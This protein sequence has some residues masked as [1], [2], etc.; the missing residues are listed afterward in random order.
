MGHIVWQLPDKFVA[1]CMTP[2]KKDLV[3]N[4]NCFI[5]V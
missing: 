1:L 2:K 4:E 5:F 3:D